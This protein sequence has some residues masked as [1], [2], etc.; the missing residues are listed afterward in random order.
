M[1]YAMHHF[2]KWKSP[3]E[4]TK[5]LLLNSCRYIDDWF[6]AMPKQFSVMSFLYFSDKN[7]YWRFYPPYLKESD[8]E[9]IKM[10]LELT[11]EEGGQVACLDLNLSIIMFKVKLPTKRTTN[12]SI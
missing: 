10:P 9:I 2:P 3:D 5:F 8:G 7:P 11:G 1:R 6:S 12:G 4:G